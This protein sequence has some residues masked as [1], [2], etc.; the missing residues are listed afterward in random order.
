MAKTYDDGKWKKD[1]EVNAEDDFSD[2]EKPANAGAE[3][4]HTLKRR[5]S[6]GVHASM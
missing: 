4:F 6:D 3:S 2:S 5:A 1:Y